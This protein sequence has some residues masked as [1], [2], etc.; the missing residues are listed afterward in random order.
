MLKNVAAV[1]L[2]GFTPFELGVACEVFSVDR[3]GDGLPGY[4]FTIVAGEPGP[5]R[6]S[7]GFV[8]DVPCDLDRLERADLVVV[9]P[10]GD[11]RYE[12]ADWP[13]PM[14]VALQRAV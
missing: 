12:R 9:L 5:L 8:I 13:E 7:A 6:S 1:V 4:D 2:D 3:T 14:L 11:E 10:A